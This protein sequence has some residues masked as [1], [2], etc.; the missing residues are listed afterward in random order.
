M[1]KTV[2]NLEFDMKRKNLLVIAPVLKGDYTDFLN[3]NDVLKCVLTADFL[4]KN[5]MPKPDFLC[6]ESMESSL[7]P[8]FTKG[9]I[10]YKL[11]EKF[12]QTSLIMEVSYPSSTTYSVNKVLINKINSNSKFVIDISG[13]CATRQFL[14]SVV[15]EFSGE[16]YC[17]GMK[18]LSG[19][20]LTSDSWDFSKN[21]GKLSVQK[22]CFDNDN[23]KELEELFNGN[24]IYKTVSYNSLNETLKNDSKIHENLIKSIEQSKKKIF[25]IKKYENTK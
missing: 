1:Y 4:N 7:K 8:E 19:F 22:F 9:I 10:L 25:N 23:D 20:L 5:N 24:S 15:P 17:K 11:N 6:Y 3:S 14:D 2:Q 21:S 16:E 12:K 13:A 18:S